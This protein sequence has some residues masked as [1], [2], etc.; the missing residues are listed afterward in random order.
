MLKYVAIYIALSMAATPEDTEAEGIEL[1]ERNAEEESVNDVSNY[2]SI[3]YSY[4][5]HD[6]LLYSH[7]Q[8][9][10]RERLFKDS[11]IGMCVMCIQICH[12]AIHVLTTN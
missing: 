11:D 10:K 3:S 2:H 8:N 4:G 6:A 5:C 1:S 7:P 12:L 9:Q